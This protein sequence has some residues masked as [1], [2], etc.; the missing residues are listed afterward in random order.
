M[1]E[2]YMDIK[3][4]TLIVRRVMAEARKFLAGAPEG[5]LQ[6]TRSHGAFQYH[7]RNKA[8]EKRVYLK[9]KDIEL[10]K[11]LAQKEYCK[12]LLEKAERVEKELAGIERMHVGR[13]ASFMYNALGEAYSMLPQGK[14]NLVKPYVLPDKEFVESWLARPAGCLAFKEGMPEIYTERGE[15]VRSKS[16]KMIADKL[17]MLGVPYRYESSIIFEN[18]ETV[19]PD[20]TILDIKE[21]KDILFEHFGL[22]GDEDY[23]NRAVWKVGMYERS[24][25]MLGESFLFTMETADQPLDMRN[26]E[27]MIRN[28]LRMPTTRKGGGLRSGGA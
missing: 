5:V 20:F 24:G 14:R 4:Q 28:R 27:K 7:V 21:R 8:G 18:G 2:Y 12:R 3:E 11:V 25:Y 13:S 1:N 15:R 10:A 9:K 26:F 22:M 23:Q 19:C 6:V 17:F 16:E